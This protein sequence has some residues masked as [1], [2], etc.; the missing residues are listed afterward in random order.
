MPAVVPQLKSI[1]VGG[2]TVGIG[3]EATSFRHGLVHETVL[4]MDV[5]L[6]D[7]RVVLCTPANE[8]RDLFHG[9]PNSYGTLGYLLRLRMRILPVKRFVR[10]ERRR[11]ADAASCFRELDSACASDAD[12][13]DGVIFSASELYVITG[14]FTDEAPF[15]SD[16]T[17][18]HIYYRS[19]PEKTVDYLTANDYI[20]R[21][22]TD[23]FWCS[24]AFGVQHPL[25]RRLIPKRFLTS[26]TYT[27]LM[28]LNAR[29]GLTDRLDRLRGSGTP[30]EAV[31]QD[32]IIPLER[33]GEFCEFLLEKIR[34][35]PIWLCPS[36]PPDPRARFPLF[37]VRPDTLSVDFGF[38]D[39]IPAAKGEETGF[40]NRLIERK[41]AELGG[42]KS[43][44]SE[45]F[46]PEEEFWSIY[47]KSAYDALKAAYDPAGSLR[48]LYQKC[49]LSV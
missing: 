38:W 20:W 14:R 40:H 11:F 35:T 21:W 43:L 16:Y 48:D 23:W 7:G 33:C 6:P 31:I 2:A 41:T 26:V 3:I 25:V 18:Q 8:H 17:G 46:Y 15:V 5:L 42:I 45:A 34:I 13:V 29:W 9:I 39:V 10:I 30:G 27:K 28:R 24:K 32:I 22:D 36:R 4:E 19:I 12:F 1:T 47:D 37:P 49:V 44:Y